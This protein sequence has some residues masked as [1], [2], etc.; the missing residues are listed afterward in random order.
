MAQLDGARSERG[1]WLISHLA[2]PLAGLG[3]EAGLVALL[4]DDE[5]DAGLVLVP[6]DVSEGLAE[7][8]KLL[9]RGKRQ[10]ASAERG[11]DSTM[12]G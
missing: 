12:M 2:V 7:Q 8:R 6:A 1:A 11:E 3:E 9:E 4:H 10:T 5:G